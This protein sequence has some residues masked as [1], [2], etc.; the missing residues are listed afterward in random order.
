MPVPVN[1]RAVFAVGT[2][3]W[4]AAAAVV[5]W[6]VQN[7]TVADARWLGVCGAGVAIGVLGWSWSRWRGW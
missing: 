3:L 5:A 6:L 7:G 2:A 4:L 1:M